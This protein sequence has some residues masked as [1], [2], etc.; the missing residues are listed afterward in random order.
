MTA[1][2]GPVKVAR[3]L[4]RLDRGGI[5][6]V[7][8]DLCR[9]I[10]PSECQ[11][12]F[13]T[14]SGG[15]GRLAPQFR[16]AGAKVWPCPLRPV[17]TLPLRL[18]RA[19]R[20]VRPD[21]V[22][23]HVSLVSGLVLAV[24]ALHGVRVRIAYLHSES[25]GKPD[26]V[27]RR[28]QRA[29]LRWLLHRYATDVVG[30]T[31]ATLAFAGPRHGDRRYRVLPN[32]IDVTRFSRARKP[33][34]GTPKPVVLTHI[35][36]ASPEKNRGFLLSVHAEAQHLQPGTRL[37]FVG[38]G[39]SADLEAVD[40]SFAANSL[41]EVLGE[42]DV[43]EDVLGACDVLLLPSHWEG[44]PGV[45]LQ[46][47]A[48]GVP[49]LAS[50]SPGIREVAAEVD[51]LTILSLD[52]SPRRWARTALRLAE[53]QAAERDAI[54]QAMLRSRFTLERYVREWKRLCLERH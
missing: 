36:R 51:G 26:T 42:T 11:Q 8:L 15:E 18:W 22:V 45:V 39:G 1:H 17:P 38:P 19:F 41:V 43:I 27:R 54:S 21:V 32:G 12:I 20:T 5:E 30:V 33:R 14:M 25:D 37:R 16:D 6:T 49:V 44:L 40:P 3:L 46:A 4:G 53:F 2:T 7:A 50:D 31:A 23:S 24:A 28:A 47:L 48:A 52:E 35:G 9:A 34:A 29:V 13:L 10:P